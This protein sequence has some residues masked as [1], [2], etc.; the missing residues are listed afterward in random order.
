MERMSTVST[1]TNAA[2]KMIVGLGNPGSRYLGNR[3]NIGFQC[4]D[5]F[6]HRHGIELAKSQFN[7]RVGDGWITRAGANP[8]D[9]GSINAGARRRVLLVK[10]MTYMNNSG[11]AV[12]PL[13]DYYDIDNEQIIVVHDDLD[14]PAGTLRLRPGGGAGGQNGIKSIIKHFGDERNFARARVG[15]GRPPGRMSPAAYVLQ[16]FARAEEDEMA[17]VREEVVDALTSWLF[18]GIDAAMNRFNGER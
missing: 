9:A 4:V 11:G 16:D 8:L 15:I 10:P 13:A 1:S 17:V 6:A 12:R 7:A 3:H 5:R 18:D 14:L 2:V